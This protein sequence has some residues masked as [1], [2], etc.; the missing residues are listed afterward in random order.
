MPMT[1][2]FFIKSIPSLSLHGSRSRQQPWNCSSIVDSGSTSIRLKAAP[3]STCINAARMMN[4][5]VTAITWPGT[6][7]RVFNQA[8]TRSPTC[9]TDSPPWGAERGSA[10]QACSD[11]AW[12]FCRSLIRT[13]RQSPKS[14]SRRSATISTGLPNS[15]AVCR[16]R[17]SGPHNTREASLNRAPREPRAD[18]QSISRGSSTGKRAS[19]CARVRA[20]QIKVKRVA[21][22]KKITLWDRKENRH[23]A[24]SHCPIVP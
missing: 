18:C 1:N 19:F 21:C 20:W 13:P 8:A 6:A 12:F 17:N 22:T 14:Q 7:S 24:V 9:A 15:S 10:S 4:G 16:V 3:C 11:S 23:L 2:S 5:W